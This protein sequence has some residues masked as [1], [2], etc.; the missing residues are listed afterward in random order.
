MSKEISLD[1]LIMSLIL[2]VLSESQDFR[3]YR[4]TLN[5]EARVDEEGNVHAKNFELIHNGESIR[6]VDVKPDFVN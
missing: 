2:S 6:P 4:M 5:F 1:E 3:R